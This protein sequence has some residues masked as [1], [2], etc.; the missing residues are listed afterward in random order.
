[1]QSGVCLTYLIFVPQNMRS[2]C[3]ALF[4]MD[5]S[6]SFFLFLMVLVQI[7]LSWIRDIRHLTVTNALAN[8][9]IMY[10]LITC[11]GFA[12][13]NAIVTI[14]AAAEE[15]GGEEGDDGGDDEDFQRDPLAEIF[16]K[17]FHL[18]PFNSSGWFL[19]I[20]TSV[21]HSQFF[22]GSTHSLVLIEGRVLD[23]VRLVWLMLLAPFRQKTC[24]LEREND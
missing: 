19:F 16:Y 6:T 8:G 20:G 4:G 24:D 17:F 1:M 15:N 3:R 10:G 11:L 18:T 13:Q 9:L 22:L 5:I 21:S 7:P 23:F 14:P 2:S 12:F